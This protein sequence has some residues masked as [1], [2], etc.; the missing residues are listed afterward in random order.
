[1]S[2]I[3]P[4]P[5]ALA[6]WQAELHLPRSQTGHPSGHDGV[7]SATPELELYSLAIAEHRRLCRQRADLVEVYRGLCERRLELEQTSEMLIH[8]C[9]ATRA[10]ANELLDELTKQRKHRI[11]QKSL[12]P[13]AES[14][15][16]GLRQ[17]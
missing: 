14:M 7:M 1:M 15:V 6:R 11:G 2:Y 17:G 10:Y 8:G 16:F 5:N 9:H 12:S 3:K 13:D 4:Y